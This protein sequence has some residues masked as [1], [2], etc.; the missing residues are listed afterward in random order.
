MKIDCHAHIMPEDWPNL[1]KKYGYG[2]FI[3]LNHDRERK[4][5]RMMRDDGKFFREVSENCWDPKAIIKDMDKHRV[6]M[7]VLSTIPVLF[8]YWAQGV[9]T[10]DWSV[11][12]NDHIANLQNTHPNRF[13]GLGTLPMQDVKL[14]IKELERCKNIGLPGVQIGTNILNMNL[15]DPILFPFYEAAEKMSMSLFIHPWQMMGE[16]V[17]EKFWLP[18][19]VG[20]P[21]ETSRA[22]CSMIFGGVFDKFP[23]LRVMFAHAGGSFPF[24]IGRISH[25]WEVRPDLVNLNEVRKPADYIGKFWVDGITHDDKAF[26]YLLDMFGSEKICYGTD[27]PFPLGDLGHGKFIEDMQNVSQKQKDQIFSESVLKFLGR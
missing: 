25:G 11:F 16:D 8:N 1:Q 13:I 23:G 2:G 9:D 24:T 14:A 5:A 17:I 20:M 12:L 22:I 3:Y 7:M 6:D 15:D 21:A 26:G 10:H 4:T 18:W 27:Y 19:L